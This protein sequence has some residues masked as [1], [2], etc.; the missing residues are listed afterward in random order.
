MVYTYIMKSHNLHKIGK[1]NNVETRLKQFQTGN[2]YIEVV[3]SIEGSYEM[4][5]HELYKDKR[6][7]GEWFKLSEEDLIEIDR[8]I[9]QK[10]SETP[11][12]EK[13]WM[14]NLVTAPYDKRINKISIEID[15]TE[16]NVSWSAINI[17][18]EL[19]EIVEKMDVESI[20]EMVYAKIS[21]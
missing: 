17:Q 13:K 8:Y 4:N 11:V 7:T 1:A 9:E 16:K 20:S 6:V 3:R 10:K 14:R 15:L 19:Y 12:Q 5:L 18:K 2:P 21:K